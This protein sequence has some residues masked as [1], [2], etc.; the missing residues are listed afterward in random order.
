[1][2]CST[3]F[4]LKKSF[5]NVHLAGDR[6]SVVLLEAIDES[7]AGCVLDEMIMAMNARDSVKVISEHWSVVQNNMEVFL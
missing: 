4:F 3:I 5:Q 2:K 1:M 6:N 7:L